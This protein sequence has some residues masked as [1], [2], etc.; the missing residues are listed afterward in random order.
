MATMLECALAYQAHGF[1]VYPLAPGTRI[2]PKG[3]HGYKDASLDSQKAH[4]WWEQCPAY[5]IGL[6]L[7]DTNILMLDID[8]GH[9]SKSDGIATIN[10]L[11]SDGRATMLPT[12]TYIEA[13]P[14]GGLHFFFTYPKEL[15][16][17]M[18]QKLFA[19]SQSEE[20][21]VD[22]NALAV[23]V[24][25]SIR[26]GKRYKAVDTYTLED[27]APAPEWLLAEIERQRTAGKFTNDFHSSQKFWSGRL[28]DRIVQGV[29]S[30]ERNS[31]LASVAGS[32]LHTGMDFDNFTRLMELVNNNFVRP[33][34]PTKELAKI[35][36]SIMRRELAQKVRR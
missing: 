5:N 11:V 22:Y 36:Q 20:T 23:P 7:A 24:A 25:P 32:L 21:G 4:D 33:P 30:G 14:S 34:L 12:D 16:L 9:A 26:Y 8:R 27:L 2:P 6:S 17:T 28:L 31:W 35:I 15:S 18:G 29:D 19:Q 10:Q 1:K 13:T 3:S